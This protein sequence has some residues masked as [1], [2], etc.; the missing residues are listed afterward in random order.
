MLQTF[1]LDDID[2]AVCAILLRIFG[3]GQSISQG[4]KGCDELLGR[5]SALQG[6]F[7]IRLFYFRDKRVM[8]GFSFVSLVGPKLVFKVT[9]G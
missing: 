1:V 8:L 9:G 7:V 6:F 4:I 2:L 3:I 5:P